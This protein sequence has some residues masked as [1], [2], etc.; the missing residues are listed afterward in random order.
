MLG[1]LFNFQLLAQTADGDINSG[2]SDGGEILDRATKASVAVVDAFHSDWQALVDGNNPIYLAIVNVCLLIASVLV[3]FWGVGLFREISDKG[4]SL[5]VIDDMFWPLLVCIMLGISKGALLAD[6]SY[7]FY[8]TANYLNDKV[9]SISRGGVTFREAIMSANVNQALAQ[10]LKVKTIE[11]QK[12]PYT[13]TDEKGNNINPRQQCIEIE[14]Q[15]AKKQVDWYREQY[16]IP[17]TQS[18]LI[19]QA[20]VVDDTINSAVQGTLY[21]VLTGLESMFQALM[22][23]LFLLTAYSGP[24]FLVLSLFPGG[25][26]AIYGWFSGWLFCGLWLVCFSIIIGNTATGI[27]IYSQ[28]DPMFLLLMQGLGA[29]ILA[30][31][32]AAFG[33]IALFFGLSS[34]ARTLV[35]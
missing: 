27:A 2:I 35:S 14:S 8:G 9:L 15:K 34:A 25:S 20:A 7:L 12:L 5:N 17:D 31:G 32:L 21:V 33:S 13:S 23:N 3:A 4:F 18:L 10:T 29:P 24:I 16:Q 22:Q 19:N 11:C 28:S 30:G 1:L 26:K 6:T